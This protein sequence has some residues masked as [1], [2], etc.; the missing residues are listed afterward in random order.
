MYSFI[1]MCLDST[2]LACDLVSIV[3]SS[4]AAKNV[5]GQAEQHCTLLV[6]MVRCL[7]STV[8]LITTQQQPVTSLE[9]LKGYGQKAAPVE[10]HTELKSNGKALVRSIMPKS[11]DVR[12]Q[13]DPEIKK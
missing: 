9:N 2:V 7:Y 12:K 6:N 4:D 3:F 5:L 8:Q 11:N 1:S 10:V 13:S